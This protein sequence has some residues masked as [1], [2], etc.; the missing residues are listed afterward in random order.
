MPWSWVAWMSSPWLALYYIENVSESGPLTFTMRK[1]IEN[2]ALIAFLTS[3][4]VAFNFMVGVVASYMSDRVW[5]R[6]GRRRPFLIVGWTGVAMAMACV[7]L[8]TNVWSLAAIIVAYQLFTDIAKPVEPLYNE[9]VPSAQRGRGGSIHNIAQQVLGLLFFG[10]LVARFD[11]MHEFEV[12]GRALKISGEMTLYW[13]GSALVLGATL[14]LVFFVRETPPPGGVVR[15]RFA[16]RTFVREVFGQRQWW[17]VYLLYITPA[18]AAPVGSFQMLIRTEQLGFSKEQLG[19][20]ISIGMVVI[21]G[22]FTPLGGYLADRMPR[23]RLFQIGLIG[24][25]VIEFIFF[26]H[27]RYYAHYSISFTTLMI[28]GV[29]AA[30]FATCAFLVWGALIFDY[31]PT[32]K[33][34]T[35]SA[36]LTFFGGL[37]PFL[38]TNLAGLWITGFTR[39]FGSAGGSHYDYSSVYIL[40]IITAVLAVGLTEFFRHEERRGKVAPLGRTE[41]AAEKSEAT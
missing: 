39:M 7:P 17:M 32:A 10:V 4:N 22:I 13:T 34:G 18:I 23:L 16:V 5:T 12:L 21:L 3:L 8:A 37:A 36:G 28:Y 27:L 31:I 40:Q 38:T 35:V 33:F 26:L 6:W 24:P 1:F 2:P 30:A 41:F 19:Y 15:E 29:L 11:Q 25:A 14:F 9:V 20:S